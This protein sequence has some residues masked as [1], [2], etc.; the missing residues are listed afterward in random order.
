VHELVIIETDYLFKFLPI[1]IPLTF[2]AL[3]RY[4]DSCIV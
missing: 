4:A 3:L 2:D 1:N